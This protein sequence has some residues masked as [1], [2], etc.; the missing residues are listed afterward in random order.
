MRGAVKS[1]PREGSITCDSRCRCGCCFRSCL[2]VAHTGHLPTCHLPCGT[3][4]F[5]QFN[6]LRG[7]ATALSDQSERVR[8]TPSGSKCHWPL[9]SQ[10]CAT[11]H[12]NACRTHTRR[13]T[14]THKAAHTHKQ[15]LTHTHTLMLLGLS[16]LSSIYGFHI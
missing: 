12:I 13:H 1:Y 6:V 11:C 8:A 4:L 5:F 7:H 9:S 2:L 14:N 15:S 3:L 10:V 16:R